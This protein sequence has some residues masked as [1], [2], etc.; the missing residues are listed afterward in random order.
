MLASEEVAMLIGTYKRARLCIQASADDEADPTHALELSR[1]R[2]NVAIQYLS[3]QYS[4]PRSQFVSEHAPIP[5]GIEPKGV[6]CIRLRLVNIP[7]S[8]KQQQIGGNR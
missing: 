4:R 3:T 1:G 8:G 5:E 6:M 7:I 2:A